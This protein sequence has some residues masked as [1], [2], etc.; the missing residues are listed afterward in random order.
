MSTQK[1]YFGNTE[2]FKMKSGETL[3]ALRFVKHGAADDK[4]AAIAAATDLA[5]GVLLEKTAREDVKVPVQ[6]DGKCDVEA[7]GVCTRGKLAKIDSVGRVVDGTPATNEVIVGQFDSSAT[8]AGEYVKV[9]LMPAIK[10][11]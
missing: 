9:K 3:T 4:I 6:Q 5:I 10:W 8:A 11:P 2:D 7:G 1:T